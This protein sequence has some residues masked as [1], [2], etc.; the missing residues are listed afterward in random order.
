M[1]TINPNT[2]IVITQYI[3][4]KSPGILVCLR[5]W[6][7]GYQKRFLNSGPTFIYNETQTSCPYSYRKRTN[8]HQ[9]F[10]HNPTVFLYLSFALAY[11]GNTA[12]DSNTVDRNLQTLMSQLTQLNHQPRRLAR[13]GG[14][15]TGVT[16]RST[17][18][19]LSQSLITVI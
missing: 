11:K 8:V 2:C 5:W 4:L 17:T 7:D 1:I 9:Q 6:R 12:K 18:N 13:G 16:L 14:D 15:G 3:H 19:P 10:L